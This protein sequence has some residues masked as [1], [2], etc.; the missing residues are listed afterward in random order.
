MC[1]AWVTCLTVKKY[2]LIVKLVE[3][4]FLLGFFSARFSS[5]SEK[6]FLFLSHLFLLAETQN[7]GGKEESKFN[8]KISNIV[9]HISCLNSKLQKNLQF[10]CFLLILTSWFSKWKVFLGSVTLWTLGSIVPLT[11]FQLTSNQ[12]FCSPYF[13]KAVI[14]THTASLTLKNLKE[15]SI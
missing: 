7:G 4:F 6:I 3:I 11:N 14:E 1:S 2:C 5:T 12:Y 8:A 9:F 13:W 15:V 10:H